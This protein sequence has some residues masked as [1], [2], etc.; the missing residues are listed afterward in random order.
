MS[1]ISHCVQN[2]DIVLLL[3]IEMKII[4]FPKPL[5]MQYCSETDLTVPHWY[6]IYQL[7]DGNILL[8]K[9]IKAYLF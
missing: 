2:P 4:Y 6:L 9:Q 7:M 8:L 1:S 3:L 5:H